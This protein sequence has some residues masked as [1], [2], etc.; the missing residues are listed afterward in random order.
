MRKKL[1]EKINYDP[2]NNADSMYQRKQ[3]GMAGT[4][5]KNKK[6]VQLS[7]KDIQ[8][9]LGISLEEPTSTKDAH[10]LKMMDIVLKNWTD[11]EYNGKDGTYEDEE[12]EDEMRDDE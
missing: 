11:D 4:E 6:K 1:K 10:G 8:D 12:Y 5:K 7:G 2:V 9:L 3:T